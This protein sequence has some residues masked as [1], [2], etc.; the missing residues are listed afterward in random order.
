MIRVCFERGNKDDLKK[1]KVG[2]P[3]SEISLVFQVE[4]VVRLVSMVFEMTE[5]RVIGL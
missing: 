5:V 2:K 4:V 3:F 1:H